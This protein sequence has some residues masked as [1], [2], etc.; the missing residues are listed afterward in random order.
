MYLQNFIDSKLFADFLVRLWKAWI[1][2]N[3]K[4][5]ARGCHL[6]IKFFENKNPAKC[7]SILLSCLRYFVFLLNWY[8]YTISKCGWQGV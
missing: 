1:T 5:C 3:L 7:V 4:D 8:Y 2:Y 6:W